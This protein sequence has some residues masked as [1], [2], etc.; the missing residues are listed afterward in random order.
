[1]KKYQRFIPKPYKR[2]GAFI[3]YF[4]PIQKIAKPPKSII[5]DET[6]LGAEFEQL[7]VIMS[8]QARSP[9]DAQHLLDRYG[10]KTWHDLKQLLPRKRRRFFWQRL[11]QLVLKFAGHD[12][13]NPYRQRP[14]RI[15]LK[16]KFIDRSNYEQ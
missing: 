16:A 8:G 15:E 2:R 5:N 7:L 10:V 3:R 11:N 12:Y 1:M 13:R 14:D 9:E 6:A 4:N